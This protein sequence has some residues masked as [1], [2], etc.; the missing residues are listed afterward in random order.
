[1]AVLVLML[2]LM[3]V[4]CA[5]VRMGN[6]MRVSVSVLFRQRVNY[7]YHSAEYHYKESDK[8]RPRWRFLEDSKREEKA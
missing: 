1:M 8:I 7:N 2:N 5:V 6:C 4:S 3:R